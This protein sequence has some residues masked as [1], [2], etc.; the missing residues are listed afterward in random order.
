VCMDP[1]PWARERA[2]LNTFCPT[3][4]PSCPPPNFKWLQSPERCTSSVIPALGVETGGLSR[5]ARQT[6][7]IPWDSVSKTEKWER[8]SGESEG[9][10]E[11]GRERTKGVLFVCLFLFF[12]S[13][14]KLWLLMI[15]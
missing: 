6:R 11:R 5:I 3:L 1:P 12:F 14:R 8:R 2:R 9:E 13:D 7:T 4:F 15:N 10:R